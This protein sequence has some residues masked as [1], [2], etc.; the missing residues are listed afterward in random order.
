MQLG[1]L[2][3]CLIEGG[4]LVS[5][6]LARFMR[7][8]VAD[9]VGQSGMIAGAGIGL[10]IGFGAWAYFR[11]RTLRDGDYGHEEGRAAFWRHLYFYLALGAGLALT[12]FG[13]VQLLRVM[14]SLGGELVLGRLPTPAGFADYSGQC[15]DDDGAGV[16]A[17]D[18]C[19]ARHQPG[20]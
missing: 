15:V 18:P 16:A 8:P 13:A 7:Q 12:V 1:A 10:V 5:D 17:G 2:G 20:D 3:V 6:L 4:L 9:P 14:L 19:L 11:R